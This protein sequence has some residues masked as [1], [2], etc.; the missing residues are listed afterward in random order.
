MEKYIG[1]GDGFPS[2]YDTK[3]VIELPRFTSGSEITYENG[4][5]W[6]RI[7]ES[8]SW[9]TQDGIDKLYA[10]YAIAGLSFDE[11]EKIK[12]KYEI[13]CKEFIRGR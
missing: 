11:I 5:P 12:L 1:K 6:V 13:A 8:A 3:Y 2:T 7:I 10:V 9:L 4:K